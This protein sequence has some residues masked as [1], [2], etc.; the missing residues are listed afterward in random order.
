MEG[1]FE[2]AGIYRDDVK[3]APPALDE[4]ILVAPGASPAALT[5]A[6]ERGVVMGEGANLARGLANRAANDVS[7][8]VLAE[9]ARTI[10]ERHGLSIE[11]LGPEQAD[12]ED[13]GVG[14]VEE[15]DDVANKVS[16]RIRLGI[17]S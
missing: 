6:A 8:D 13:V 2:P 17:R 3:S 14:V 7:P 1:S 9:E 12:A 11:V 4:L 5:R 16:Q 10:A 15:V